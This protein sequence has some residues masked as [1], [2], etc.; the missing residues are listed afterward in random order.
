VQ[1][2]DHPL[3]AS[4][5]AGLS[6]V[7]FDESIKPRLRGW[8][9]AL[10]APGAL[11]AT[12]LLLRTTANDPP[13]FGS[14]LVFGLSLITLYAVS[15]IYHLGS[16]RGRLATALLAWDHANIFLLI[17][18]TY[19]P[20]AVTV[21]SGP[22]RLAILIGIWLLAA[23]GMASA[24]V[25]LHLPRWA[26]TALY[27]G[28][29]WVGLLALPSLMRALPLAAILLLLSGGLLYTLGAVIYVFGRPNPWPHSF[30]FHEIFHLCVIAGSA[31]TVAMIAIWVIPFP[32]H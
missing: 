11:G 23:L 29:G 15:A 25:T 17:A 16:W 3:S 27:L 8:S 5:L 31:A 21:L 7:G 22:L 28:M 2:T 14:C 24:L 4:T 12:F 6:P 26:L 9:H 18:G 30:G 1:P 10:A 20:I 32:Q 13:R 19:T